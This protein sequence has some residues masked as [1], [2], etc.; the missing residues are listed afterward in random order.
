MRLDHLLL[1]PDLAG[2]L[3]AAGVDRHARG[4]EGASDHAPTWIEL[5]LDA[6]RRTAVGAARRPRAK[7]AAQRSVR[8]LGTAVSS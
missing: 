4:E 1:S 7:A 3:V 6:K 8:R 5:N 2:R